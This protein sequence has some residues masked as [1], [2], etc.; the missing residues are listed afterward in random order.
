MVLKYSERVNKGIDVSPTVFRY[1]NAKFFFFTREESRMHIH[2]LTPDGEAKIW[3]E[4]KIE[5]AKTIKL[6]PH[7]T[8][9]L[10]KI[11]KER[12][13]EIINAWNKRHKR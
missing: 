5:L 8:N 7:E 11:V 13:N 1:K 2:V 10:I 6:K 12:E 3:M 9:R 4:P